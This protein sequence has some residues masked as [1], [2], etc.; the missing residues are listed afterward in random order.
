[1]ETLNTRAHYKQRK[2]PNDQVLFA[3]HH[4]HYT[5][6]YFRRAQRAR[7]RHGTTNSGRYQIVTHRFNTII[8]RLFNTLTTRVFHRTTRQ[9]NSVHG[10]IKRTRDIL[11]FRTKGRK[12][13]PL[14][15]NLSLLHDAF[16]MLPRLHVHL[17]PNVTRRLNSVL[18]RIVGLLFELYVTLAINLHPDPIV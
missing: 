2:V 1:M 5:N 3:N 13:H 11:I 17:L 12:F 6:T 10:M 4:H 14:N 9:L 8:R 7:T 15:R 18:F 16:T